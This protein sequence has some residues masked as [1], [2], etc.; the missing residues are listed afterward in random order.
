MKIFNIFALVAVLTASIIFTLSV[1]AFAENTAKGSLTVDGDTTQIKHAYADIYDGDITIILVDNPIKREMIPDSVYS[2]GEQGKIKGI[3]FVVSE[4][5]KKLMSGG[6]Y[7]LINAIHSHPKWNKL[8]TVGNGVLEITNS[9]GETLAG[10]IKTPSENE[11]DGHKF[12][13]YISFSVSLKKEK[14]ELTMTG[15]SDDPSKAFGA[16]GKALFAGDIEQYK[17]Y[18]SK[19]IIE[20]LPDDVEELKSGMEFQ[21]SVFPNMIYIESS[22]ITG[23]KAE[24]KA[25]GKRGEE[26]SKG[27]ITMLKEDGMW[28]VNKQSWESE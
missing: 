20:M 25:M 7:N 23:N 17:K 14:L 8:G 22:E 16:W 24:L 1:S 6:L 13:Y 12:T 26:I 10:K 21:E 15:K 9:E 27:T 18:C 5:E 4:N 11:V 3:V 19:E 2:L 28:K